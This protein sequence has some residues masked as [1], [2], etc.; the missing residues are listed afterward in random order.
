MGSRWEG[1]TGECCGGKRLDRSFVNEVARPIRERRWAAIVLAAI[2][3]QIVSE[4][5]EKHR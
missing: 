3:H 4:Y 5:R 1:G 2:V